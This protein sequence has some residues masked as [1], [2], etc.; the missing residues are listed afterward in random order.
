[1]KLDHPPRHHPREKSNTRFHLLSLAAY[2]SRAC[3][4]EAAREL[5]SNERR[6]SCV[7]LND[8]YPR[9]PSSS[10][11]LARPQPPRLPSPPVPGAYSFPHRQLNRG[12][13]P[14]RYESSGG[15]FTQP[16]AIIEYLLPRTSLYP[17]AIPRL[18]SPP[19]LSFSAAND[20]QSLQRLCDAYV[21]T[22]DQ[23]REVGT[24]STVTREPGFVSCFATCLAN[25]NHLPLGSSYLGK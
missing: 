22:R 5:R 7:K 4:V 14:S 21:C 1:M 6:G 15:C 25:S 13:H 2:I 3:T 12:S 8:D 20:R 9:V 11:A 18:R 10:F 24:L 19:P 16:S 17:T 23:R